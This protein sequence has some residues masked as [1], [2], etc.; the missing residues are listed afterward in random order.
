M[1]RRAPSAPRAAMLV[2]LVLAAGLLTSCGGYG[3]A[4]RGAYDAT[5][6]PTY[7]SGHPSVAEQQLTL[8]A[9]EGYR[10]YLLT[11]AER[12]TSELQVLAAR[13]RS[14]N[15]AGARTAELAAQVDFDAVRGD[16][17]PD[18]AVAIQLDGEAWSVGA[19]PFAGLHRI[20]REL[21]G[22]VDLAAAARGAE[23]L[24]ALS[25][26]VAFVFYRAVLTP[27]EMLAQAQSQLEWAVDVPLAG[28]EELYSHHDLA[29]VAAAIGAART[30]FE[31]VSPLGRLV[32]PA[33]VT[34]GARRFA[35]LDAALRPLGRPASRTDASVGATT[36][37]S[38]AESA[39]DANAAVG[40]LAGDVQGFGSGRLYA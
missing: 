3:A 17:A 22:T 32:A 29:D 19:S 21:W 26:Q 2:G 38:I 40:V 14:G 28:R 12:L 33:A 6:T 24:A 20:E 15:L 5:T 11:S 16:I 30:A 7:G 4:A 31:L 36:W 10:R 8:D 18:S 34:S 25:D 39:Q 27:A 23:G 1:S 35:T 13:A 37:A 9:T